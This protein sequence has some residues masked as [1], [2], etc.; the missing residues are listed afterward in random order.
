MEYVIKKVDIEEVSIREKIINLINE[1]FSL[2]WDRDKILL[3][4]NTRNKT[5]FFLAA[6]WGEEI[7]AVNGF[8]GHEF[9]YNN[10]TVYAHQSCW[11]A[12]AK[13]HRK[14]GLFTELIN[15]GKAMSKELGSLFLFGYPNKYSG[16]IFFNKLGFRKITMRRVNIPV[17]FFSSLML[18]RYL[19]SKNKNE[20]LDVENR[21]IPIEGELIDLKQGE[22]GDKIKVYNGYNNVLWGRINTRKLGMLNLRFFITGGIQINKPHL[23]DIVFKQLIKKESIDV[24]QIVGTFDHSLWKLFRFDKEAAQ[25]EPLA[26]FDLNMDTTTSKFDFLIGI[27]DVF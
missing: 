24:I 2:Q 23:L 18:G 25:T 10:E 13:E 22:Y 12:T 19:V 14:K 6:Y 4:T 26:I 21:F 16:P 20:V 27:K 5:S 11:S 9:L 17:K 8:I 15:Q 1:V 3:N 7:A